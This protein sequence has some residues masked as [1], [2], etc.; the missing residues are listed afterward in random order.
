MCRELMSSACDKLAVVGWKW[1]DLSFSLISER[2]LLSPFLLSK[3]NFSVFDL[4]CLLLTTDHPITPTDYPYPS[5]ISLLFCLKQTFFHHLSTMS[6]SSFVSSFC[7][8][9][10]LY[11]ETTWKS[12]LC[13]NLHFLDMYSGF[14]CNLA[15][16]LMMYG[17]QYVLNS[18]SYHH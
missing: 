17:T 4:D 5:T 12:C 11:H 9:C 6:I 16:A 14:S 18:S 8:C 1:K 3:P 15:S 2:S 10:L 13:W 7:W